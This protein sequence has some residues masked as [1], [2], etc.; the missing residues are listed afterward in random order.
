MAHKQ[1]RF[2]VDSRDAQ[3]RTHVTNKVWDAAERLLNRCRRGSMR[4]LAVTER[5]LS[6]KMDLPITGR[7]F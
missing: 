3:L 2:I 1:L 7:V 6:M 5:E 4:C